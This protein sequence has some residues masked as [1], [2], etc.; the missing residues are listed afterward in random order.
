MI[1][2]VSVIGAVIAMVVIAWVFCRWTEG[3]REG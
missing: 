2:L 3:K 1:L